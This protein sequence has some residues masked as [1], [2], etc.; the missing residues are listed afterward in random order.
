VFGGGVFEISVKESQFV[1]A[2]SGDAK[3]PLAPKDL[4]AVLFQ[5]TKEKP[6][7]TKP[8]PASLTRAFTRTHFAVFDVSMILD[9]GATEKAVSLGALES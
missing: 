7:S 1:G 2:L 9:S 8:E 5:L 3:E 6:A 4:K